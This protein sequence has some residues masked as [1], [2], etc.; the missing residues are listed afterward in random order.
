MVE[1][2][3]FVLLRFAWC[4]IG[5]ALLH[6]F[7]YPASKCQLPPKERVVSRLGAAAASSA[8]AGREEG[9]FKG[10]VDQSPLPFHGNL[11]TSHVFWEQPLVDAHTCLLASHLNVSACWCMAAGG[12]FS[13]IHASDGYLDD[14]PPLLTE[15]RAF[16]TGVCFD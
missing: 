11:R 10:T 2:V 4:F 7:A 9:C 15:K 5:F 6:W 8:A 1:V 16:K 14:Q 3:L 12:G 13:R